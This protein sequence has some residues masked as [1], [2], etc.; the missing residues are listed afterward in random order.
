MLSQNEIKDIM[1]KVM[2]ISTADETA[3]RVGSHRRS[4]TRLAENRIHQNV[5]EDNASLSVN[6]ILG[7]RM[8]ERLG[9]R[10]EVY[11]R[12]QEGLAEFRA[13]PDKYDLVIT[14]QTMPIM[15]GLELAFELTRIRA[16][17]PILL[18]TGYSETASPLKLKEAGIRDVLLK[19]LDI[20]NLSVS[21][22][23]VLKKAL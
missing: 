16:D 22:K 9:Y 4:L 3:A 18:I 14:D 10:V 20:G 7:K 5:S 12:S 6:A 1:D 13:N 23:R 21:I 17:I 8:L 11:T 2:D 19:P 15:T